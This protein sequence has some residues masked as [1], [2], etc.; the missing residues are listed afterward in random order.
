[1]ASQGPS[2]QSPNLGL[3]RVILFLLPERTLHGSEIA[4]V[5]VSIG[6][7]ARTT[8]YYGVA[9]VRKNSKKT[10]VGRSVRDKRETE[11]LAATIKEAMSS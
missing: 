2:R 11:W 9:I 3:G 8:V 10:K 1:V 7:H 4:D 6:M 5:V